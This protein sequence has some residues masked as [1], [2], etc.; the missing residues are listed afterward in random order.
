MKII[1]NTQ[2]E[3]STPTTTQLDLLSGAILCSSEGLNFGTSL[4]EME[5]ND[6][7]FTW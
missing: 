3:Y 5:E 7:T 1:G 2:P 4:E 6:Y